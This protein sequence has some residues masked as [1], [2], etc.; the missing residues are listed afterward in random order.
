M[1]L[2]PHSTWFRTLHRHH[3][4]GR[5]VWFCIAFLVVLAAPALAAVHPVPLEPN[6]DAKKC[7]ECHEDKTK[8]ASVHSA[9]ATGCLSCHEVRVNRNV[10]HVKLITA[11]PSSLCVT[12]HADKKAADI[13]GTV[14]SPAI[15][16]CLNCHDPH[17][18]ANKNQLLKPTS[19]GREGE[20]LQQL[21]SDGAS[22][23]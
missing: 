20:P 6:T 18:S 11:T 19:G 4:P 9:M 14:H 8:G 2:L 13:K 1:N 10:T 16:D 5:D 23:P 12:C 7:L 15:R 21:P 3:T 17:A 22:C